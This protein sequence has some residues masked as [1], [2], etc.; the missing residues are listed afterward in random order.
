MGSVSVLIRYIRNVAAVSSF[1]LATA[2]LVGDEPRAPAPEFSSGKTRGIFFD[3]IEDAFRGERP[4]LSSLR[5]NAA[6]ASS[7]TSSA[8][9]D[10]AESSESTNRWTKLISPTSLEDEVKRVRL[11]YDSVIT[12][13]GAFNGGGYQDA[14]LDLSILAT[15]FAVIDLH[16]EDVR[17]KDQAAAARDLLART[18]FNCKAGS[19]QVYNEAK[20]RKADLQDLVSGSGLAD[21]DADELT[22]WS[23][24]VDRSPM[25]EYAEATLDSLKGVTNNEATAKN[26]VDQVRREAEVLAVIGLVLTQEGMD[27]FDD[28]DYAALSQAMTESARAAVTALERNDFEEVRKSVGA[29]TQSCDACH[30]Q[31]R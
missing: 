24:I 22:D 3:S 13:P 16:G 10:A 28:A 23:S 25:M 8:T 14:R 12:T 4:T 1:V 31:Y 21:R 9:A 26:N 30:E 7:K 17:W 29:I 5:K 15:M 19:T 6:S 27:D 2:G 20:L 11:H 18:A